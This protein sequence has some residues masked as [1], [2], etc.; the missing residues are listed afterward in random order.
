MDGGRVR[1]ASLHRARPFGRS[2]RS[3]R[4]ECCASLHTACPRIRPLRIRGERVGWH[5]L[6]LC[7]TSA[8]SAARFGR[9]CSCPPPLRARRRSEFCENHTSAPSEGTGLRGGGCNFD[10]TSKTYNRLRR[11]TLATRNQV[12]GFLEDIKLLGRLGS[13]TCAF[14]QSRLNG[15]TLLVRADEDLG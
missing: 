3:P 9:G 12:S 15:F 5:R 1:Q 7:R 6:S 4:G 2:E 10:M 11:L 8:D 13:R 14:R